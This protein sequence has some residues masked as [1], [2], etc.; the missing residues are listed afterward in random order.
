MAL[1]YAIQGEVDSLDMH[2]PKERN[3]FFLV[4]EEFIFSLIFI[5]IYMYAKHDWV[6]P[7]MDFGL[8]AYTMMGIQYVCAAMSLK[9][10]GGALN[11]SIGLCAVVFS[12]I[13]RSGDPLI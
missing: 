11:P 8:R 7:S 3:V 1:A 12:L 5:T 6:S 2:P 10:T 13:V 4:F 9:C